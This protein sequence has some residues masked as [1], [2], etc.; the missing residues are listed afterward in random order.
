MARVAVR[1]AGAAAIARR[2]RR[3]LANATG[4]PSGGRPEG[5]IVLPCFH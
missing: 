4:R 1:M 5:P 3:E 2:R